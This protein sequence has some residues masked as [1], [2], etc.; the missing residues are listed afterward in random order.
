MARQAK[1]TIFVGNARRCR[2]LTNLALLLVQQLPASSREPVYR[3]LLRT[4][5]DHIGQ[6][7]EAAAAIV[8]LLTDNTPKAA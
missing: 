6:P 2:A 7:D 4:L 8:R 1:R 5:R 3:Q